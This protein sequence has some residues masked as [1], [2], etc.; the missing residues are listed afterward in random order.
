MLQ[1]EGTLLHDGDNVSEMVG[2]TFVSG[3]A[4]HS[5][6][7]THTHTLTNTHMNVHTHTHAHST[8]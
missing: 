1:D 4:R 5:L 2:G 8:H 7:H 3:L 6:T